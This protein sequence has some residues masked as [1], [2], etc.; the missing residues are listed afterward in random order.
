MTNRITELEI[1]GRK[2]PL[3]FS[4]KAAKEVAKRYGDIAN[5]DKAFKDKTIDEMMDEAIWILALLI[6]QGV[7]YKKIMD[8]EEI[9][10]LSIEELEIVMGVA[11]FTNLK[12]TI[13]GAM[14]AGMVREVE[15]EIDPKNEKTTQDQ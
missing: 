3:N 12:S 11:D 6:E 9:K 2:Y 10:G 8:N 5:I 4:T 15:V 7:A 14:T 13:L 1:A